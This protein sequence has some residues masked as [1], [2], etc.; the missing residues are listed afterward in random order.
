MDFDDLLV[1]AL[2]LLEEHAFGTDLSDAGPRD[3]AVVID[4]QNG[5]AG[6]VE[7]AQVTVDLADQPAGGYGGFVP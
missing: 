2:R 3:A 4:T 7:Q 1:N 5:F 6:D